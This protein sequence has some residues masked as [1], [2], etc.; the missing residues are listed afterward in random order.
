MEGNRDY[1]QYKEGRPWSQVYRPGNYYSSNELELADVEDR[2]ADS[3]EADYLI[4]HQVADAY[5]G[6]GRLG[7]Q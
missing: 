4:N 3:A 1:R 5:R 2:P 7:G 6:A